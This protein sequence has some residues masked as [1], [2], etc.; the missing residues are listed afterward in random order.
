MATPTDVLGSRLVREYKDYNATTGTWTCTKG[1]GNATQSTAA[2]RPAASTTPSGQSCPNFDA[3]STAAQ[4]DYLEIPTLTTIPAF[5]NA[6]HNR[7]FACIYRRSGVMPHDASIFY[8]CVDVYGVSILDGKLEAC[9]ASAN[10][11][12][13]SGAWHRMI[14]VKNGS[15]AVTMYI[16]GVAQTTTGTGQLGQEW[17]LYAG[18]LGAR[19][20]GDYPHGGELASMLFA[21]DTTT[22]FSSGDIAALDAAL[23]STY[24]S[25]GGGGSYTLPVT[26]LAVPFSGKNVGLVAGRKLPVTA[27]AIPFSGKNVSAAKGYTLS[28]TA[29]A[30]AV[31]TQNVA[32]RKGS[33]LPVTSAA[34]PFSGKT[35]GT[36]RGYRASVT[37]VANA[38]SGKSV[39]LL[40][41]RRLPVSVAAVPCT[42]QDVGLKRGLRLPVTTA[43]VA[44]SAKNV[45]LTYTPL[46]AF[47]LPVTALAIPVAGQNVTFKRGL[48]LPVTPASI[49][50]SGKNVTLTYTPVGAYVLSVAAAAIPFAGKDVQL[51]RGLRLPVAPATLA[52]AGQ[53]VT[54]RKGYAL[55]VVPALASFTGREVSF[56]RT[57]RL[58]AA[59]AS[60]AVA[61]QAVGLRYSAFIESPVADIRWTSGPATIIR[62]TQQAATLI[63]V[64]QRMT[65]YVGDVNHIDFDLRNPDTRAFVDPTALDVIVTAP[66]GT[67]TTYTYGAGTEITKSATGKFRCAVPCTEAGRWSF[68]I[69][70]PGPVAQG[71][72]AGT[73]NVNS[74]A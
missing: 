51:R 6:S 53:N 69:S 74:V 9:G 2:K 42:G 27:L 36:L 3:S 63:T 28:V 32:L 16:D 24:L 21:Y 23:D 57:Y 68:V 31:A 34:I 70:S 38:F 30:I 22:P 55:S 48:R 12:A 11:V 20:N 39:N 56:R 44:F 1:S 59:T 65:L 5:N 71:A 58:V 54:G 8:R 47:V 25:A 62:V 46:G 13:D 72:K 37:P 19:E 29:S 33:R 26:A 43:A 66:S 4:A 73:F 52:V 35:V 7:L 60:I 67:S 15:G 50:F 14:V 64:R 41:G 45:T 10:A 49:P 61:A 17:R 18:A 40:V